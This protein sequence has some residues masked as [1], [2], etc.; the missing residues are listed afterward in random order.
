MD[1]QTLN[2][3]ARSDYRLQNIGQY[4]IR[5]IADPAV[6]SQ[7]LSLNI[8]E[9][10]GQ[11]TSIEPTV[12]PTGAAA[13]LASTEPVETEE[14]GSLTNR[15]RGLLS[16]A[17]WFAATVFI[18]MISGIFYW[19]GWR[20]QK[21]SWNPRIPFLSSIGGYA[22]YFFF[23]IGLP[24]STGSILKNGSGIVFLWVILGS[25]VGGGIG[26]LWYFLGRSKK[27]LKNGANKG[28][29]KSDQR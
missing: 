26:Y 20:K 27:D 5:V 23:T 28:Q 22:A 8:T 16:V 1:T 2:G 25:L 17:D 12:I 15:E 11:I 13:T 24:V 14:A 3:I 18:F 10:G 19:W 6:T 4:T 21:Y 7:I 29:K 9:T